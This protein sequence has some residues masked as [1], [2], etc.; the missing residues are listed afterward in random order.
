M[1]V[2]VRALSLFQRSRRDTIPRLLVDSQACFRYTTGPSGNAA[3]GPGAPNRPARPIATLA[4]TSSRSFSST[5]ALFPLSY[6]PACGPD[7]TR[8]GAFLHVAE[9]CASPIRVRCN[10]SRRDTIPRLP[11]L[12]R[13][14]VK[15]RHVATTPQDQDQDV[16]VRKAVV[17]QDALPLSYA[18]VSGRGR[19]R[20]GDPLPWKGQFVSSSGQ[21]TSQVSAVGFE[22]T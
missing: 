17:T 21:G 7:R 10:W 15:R 20:T 13:G 3:Y 16:Q 2:R 5:E 6:G 1:W 11:A 14:G 22:P 19:I 18:P 9:L 12:P 8:T 4:R